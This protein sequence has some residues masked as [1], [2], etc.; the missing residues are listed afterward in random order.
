MFEHAARDVV[1]R[2]ALGDRDPAV[3]DDRAL[4]VHASRSA[5]ARPRA[6]SSARR[7]ARRRRRRR[8][9]ASRRRPATFRRCWFDQTGCSRPPL[10]SS[11]SVP[12]LVATKTH[13]PFQTAGSEKTSVGPGAGSDCSS[14]PVVA[15]DA[16]QPVQLQQAQDPVLAA[17]HGVAVRQQ[18]RARRAEVDVVVVQLLVVRRRVVAQQLRRVG[19]EHEHAVAPV[20]AGRRTARC[21][22]RRR[23]RRSP[24]RPPRRSATR[25]PSRSRCS[26][27]GTIIACRSLQSEFQTCAIRPVRSDIV[28][29]WPWY[30]GASPM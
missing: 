30:G 29:T 27:L 14:P 6:R 7:R 12:A 9:A 4:P 5:A 23:G 3:G 19:R 17:L 11:A 16:R 8:R 22:S 10:K 28:T 15:F 2:V 21:R 13:L 24:G 1:V 26:V 18:R 20:R 25:S